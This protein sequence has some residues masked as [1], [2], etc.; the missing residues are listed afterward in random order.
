MNTIDSICKVVGEYKRYPVY[1]N[2]IIL[3]ALLSDLHKVV[4]P[5]DR[6]IEHCVTIANKKF[7]EYIKEL[8]RS[9]DNFREIV[10]STYTNHPRASDG[11]NPKILHDTNI[12]VKMDPKWY[13]PAAWHDYRLIHTADLDDYNHGDRKETKSIDV[14]ED[15]LMFDLWKLIYRETISTSSV[16]WQNMYVPEIQSS[17]FF[18]ERIKET[19]NA[20]SDF[21]RFKN[22]ILENEYILSN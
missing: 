17:E 16:N 4:D 2:D 11:I 5:F 14:D 10:T 19:K 6:H 12:L 3:L 18:T 22:I 1:K 21:D 13:F 9:S 8:Y 7:P 20:I 15:R